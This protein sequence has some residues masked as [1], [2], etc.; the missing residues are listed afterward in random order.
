[1]EFEVNFVT[2]KF[3]HIEFCVISMFITEDYEFAHIFVTSSHP[4]HYS[5]GKLNT[6]M[7]FW[8]FI[9]SHSNRAGMPV[10]ATVALFGNVLQ[11]SHNWAFR[12]TED[13][14][15][16]PLKLNSEFSELL[17]RL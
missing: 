15:L 14:F 8:G 11:A 6:R 5:E 16:K 12:Q 13:F 4:S 2:V 7:D 9:Y 3:F 1:M 17:V 10:M